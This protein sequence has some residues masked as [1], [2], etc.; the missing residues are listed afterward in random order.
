[1]V[2]T[3]SS[4][5]TNWP[6]LFPP[7]PWKQHVDRECLTSCIWECLISQASSYPGVKGHSARLAIAMVTSRRPAGERSHSFGF[8]PLK[9]S[10]DPTRGTGWSA[11]ESLKAEM[12]SGWWSLWWILG[13][14]AIVL[15]SRGSENGIYVVFSGPN[16]RP[17]PP[18]TGP[19]IVCSRLHTHYIIQWSLPSWEGGCVWWKI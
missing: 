2:V 15:V 7:P 17:D 18:P 6:P 9:S 13:Q 3:T 4:H 14:G 11:D 1:M 10:I 5:V 19:S 16:P 12:T 8:C